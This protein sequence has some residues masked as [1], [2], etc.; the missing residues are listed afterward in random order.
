MKEDPAL[1]DASRVVAPGR[2]SVRVA[3][4]VR[5]QPVEEGAR[6]HE[7]VRAREDEA[8]HEGRD[9][10]QADEEHLAAL[11]FGARPEEALERRET[12]HADHHEARVLDRAPDPEHERRRGPHRRTQPKVVLDSEPENRGYGAAVRRGLRLAVEGPADYVVCLHADGQYP[13]EKLPEFLP[14]MEKHGVDVLQGSRHKAGTAREGG[15]PLYKVVAGH[16]LTWLEN[17]TFG[18]QMTDYHSGFMLYSRRAVEQIPFDRLSTYFDFDLEVIAS[19]R[20]RRLTVAEQAIPTRYA[21]EE[22]HPQP[23]LVRASLPARDGPLSAGGL[24]AVGLVIVRH[25]APERL[26]KPGLR[27]PPQQPLRLGD[28]R[29]AAVTVFVPVAVELFA[30]NAPIGCSR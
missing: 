25:R 28:A 5:E 23:D 20:A 11:R 27:L 7:H 4:V 30:G 26:R 14:Y 1:R 13:P 17:K 15:M 21:D 10:G 22:S 24:S 2:S 9:Q 16:I 6:L 29:N 18:L 3:H 12:E 8:E 19:A